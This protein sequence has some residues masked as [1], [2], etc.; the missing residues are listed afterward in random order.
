MPFRGDPRPAP[1]LWPEALSSRWELGSEA[2]R[3]TLRRSRTARRIDPG[4]RWKLPFR[5]LEMT[6][7]DGV[8]LSAWYVDPDPEARGPEGLCAVLHHHYGG[9]RATVLPWVELFH[10][11]GVAALCFDARGHAASDSSPPGRGSF[12]ARAA[13]VRAAVRAARAMGARRILGFGQSQ[14]AAVLLMGLADCP[15]VRGV[16]TDCGPAPD[17][18]SAAWGLAGNLLDEHGEDWLSRALLALRILPGTEPARYLVRLWT[19]S[20]QL[21]ST[22]LLWL[23]GGRDT[24]IEPRWSRRW[25]ETMQPMAPSWSAHAVPEAD[26]VRTLAVDP[27]GVSAA[28]ASL[29]ERI[30]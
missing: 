5:P 3:R 1:R 12:P 28:V 11:L 20:W 29:I 22:P 4:R 21:R 30:R 7:D 26:H 16:I 17:M 6:T 25:F 14:G 19:A 15:E 27:D 2:I 8:R 13:D 10:R 9:Q 23:H 18:G 24:V